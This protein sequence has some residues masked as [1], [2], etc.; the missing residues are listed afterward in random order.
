MLVVAAV[1]AAL[2]GAERVHDVVR[3]I[4][5]CAGGV[6]RLNG[7]YRTTPRAFAE[8][9]TVI[10]QPG[11][12]IEARPGSLHFLQGA[13]LQGHLRFI[14]A[15]VR[16][17]EA[18]GS[19]EFV[20]PDIEFVDCGGSGVDDGGAL[21]VEETLKISNGNVSFRNG[22][23]SFG[24]CL[25]VGDDLF[26]EGG[27]MIFQ[28][29][30]GEDGGSLYVL[31]GHINQS[32][33][34]LKFADSHAIFSGGAI[35]THSN[36]LQ[37]G[38]NAS[39]R[40]CSA[41]F[42][43]GAIYGYAL[44]QCNRSSPCEAAMDFQL[45]RSGDGGAVRADY[46]IQ[47]LGTRMHFQDCS[48]T[49]SGGALHISK[50][51]LP[52]SKHKGSKGFRKKYALVNPSTVAVAGRF[53]CERCTAV[54][55]GGGIK[56]LFVKASRH[57]FMSFHNCSAGSAGGIWA[58]RSLLLSDGRSEFVNT[59]A[60]YASAAYS[61]TIAL[62]RTE[63][64][65]TTAP[66]IVAEE[67]AKLRT[68]TF[69]DNDEVRVVAP[70]LT[71]SNVRC[72]PGMSSNV[73]DF[74]LE[75][76][77]CQAGYTQTTDLEIF[78]SENGSRSLT[79]RCLLGPDGAIVGSAEIQM[80]PGYM[81]EL[82]NLSRSFLCPNRNACYG[83]E[84]RNGSFHMCAIGYEGRGCAT[85]S[86]SHGPSD[87]NFNHCL[88]CAANPTQ[89]YTQ[90]AQFVLEDLLIF[91]MSAAGVTHATGKTKESSIFTNQFMSFVAVA[92]PVLLAV[93]ESE[94]F[95][96]TLEDLDVYLGHMSSVLDIGE[97]S[98][99][100]ICTACLLGYLGLPVTSTSRLFL[101]L[102]IPVC[103]VL[104]LAVVKDPRS[105]LVVGV[106]CFLPK[107]CMCFG[108]YLVC[109]RMEPEHL[110]GELVCEYAKAHLSPWILL[111]I[112]AAMSFAGPALWAMLIR[113]KANSDSHFFLYLTAPYKDEFKWWEVTRLVRKTLLAILCAVFPIT[114]HPLTQITGISL[115]MLVTLVLEIE[116]QPY[117]HE[118]WNRSERFLSMTSMFMV[119]IALYHRAAENVSLGKGLM[120]VVASWPNLP[121]HRAVICPAVPDPRGACA[122]TCRTDTDLTDLC[123]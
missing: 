102:L 41:A 32:G 16:C 57:S 70:E 97:P 74:S 17:V 72:G 54:H 26:M 29:C 87:G 100:G 118:M 23:A 104:A 27:R 93:R 99:S 24:G 52:E 48:A 85:C 94:S 115:V 79:R 43:G 39:F 22:T 7:K 90:I 50:W 122:G 101:L 116:V 34:S 28:G 108:Q 1:A 68:V 13:R 21:Y 109:Y 91:G 37:T 84:V 56:A 25:F 61:S 67:V 80:H 6:L 18:E 2:V 71:A 12:E 36:F 53:H 88:R 11:T 42:S 81:V 77:R 98:A 14:G 123:W 86:S 121:H 15:G 33:G 106:N 49:R 73:Q 112:V 3:D 95:H 59:T 60:A 20:N 5:D 19:L 58:G 113:D 44:E 55:S 8:N 9:C 65:R 66:Q 78:Q 89:Q 110:G 76:S 111:G 82:S 35:F 40:N 92:S 31:R 119:I 83:G 51:P 105:A 47:N 38:G 63:L 114:L 4:P 45:C 46:F 107:L 64:H 103:L 75:C 30:R 120:L 69:V 10:G 117:K 62:L 96:E